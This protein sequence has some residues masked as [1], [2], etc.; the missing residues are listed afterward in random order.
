VTN[1]IDA[2][3]DTRTLSL[4][5]AVP[6]MDI[7]G[8]YELDGQVIIFRVNGNGDFVTSLEDVTGTGQAKIVA[9]G[10]PGNQR[11]TVTN[12]NIDFDIGKAHVRMNN[13]FN[14][15]LPLL[16]Q[17]VNEWIS[18]NSD[19]VINAVKP[20]IRRETIM[21]VERVLN[22]AFSKVPAQD[23]IDNLARSARGGRRGGRIFH[24]NRK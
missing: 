11:L 7:T 19:L 16:A 23:F 9:V 22:D 20:Q 18:Q 6:R 5:M 4:S 21:I 2:D 15:E 17:R 8:R 24:Y 14:G 1:H 3:I 12:T 13:L 10:P